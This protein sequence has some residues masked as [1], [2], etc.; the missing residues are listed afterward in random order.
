MTYKLTED[1]TGDLYCRITLDWDYINRTVD[2]SMPG[3][4]KKKIQEYGHIVPN[5]MQKCPYLPDPKTL[6]SIAQAPLPPDDTPKLDKKGIKCV[7]QIVGSILYYARS[8][9]MTVLMAL[10]SI[11]AKQTKAT[12]KTMNRCI[13]LLDYLATN[14]MAKIRFH[15]SEM[16]LN[17]HSDASNLSETGAHSRACG[18][19]FMGWMPKDNKPIRLNGAFH[20]NSTIMRFVVMSA[21]KAKLGTLFHNCQRGIIF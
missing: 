4:I 1:W 17:I 15:A 18:H 13:Q 14:E 20:T 10:S 6:G 2:I 5:R 12:E 8:V 19:F 21:A 9:D 16:I 7:Q 11:A 3:Y